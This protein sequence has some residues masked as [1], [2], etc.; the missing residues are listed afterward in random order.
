MGTIRSS[1]SLQPCF[2][3]LNPISLQLVLQIP[4]QLRLE[5]TNKLQEG[6]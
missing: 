1:G 2:N 3:R 4:V 6:T 5:P